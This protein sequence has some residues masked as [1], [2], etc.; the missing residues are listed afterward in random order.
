L[1]KDEAGRWVVARELAW[2]ELPARVEAVIEERIGRLEED[3]KD[4]L[5]VASVEGEDFTAQVVARVQE[6]KERRLLHELSHELEKRHRLVREQGELEVQGHLLSRFRFAHQLYQR[7]LYNNLGLGERRLLHREIAEVL[8]DIY[9]GHADDHAVQLALH[10]SQAGGREKARYYLTEAGHQARAKYAN[11]EAIR[12]YSGALAL[13]ADDDPQR[14]DLLQAR[15][16]VFRLSGRHEEQ[17]AD[18]ESMSVYAKAQGDEG[19]LCD[20]LIARADHLLDTHLTSAKEPAEEALEIARKLGDKVRQ[21]EALRR[22]GF[23]AW[24]RH[25][26]QAS[27]TALASA[28]EL[29]QEEGLVAK[30]ASCLHYLSLTLSAL[31][32]HLVALETAERSVALSREAGDPRQEA[33]GLRRMALAHMGLQ[34]HAEALPLTQQALILHRELGD[35][36]EEGNDLNALGTIRAWLQDQ[37]VSERYLRESLE[38]AITIGSSATARAAAGNLTELHYLPRGDYEFLLAFAES[39]IEELRGY[40]DPLLLAY[41]ESWKMLAWR[42]LGEYQRALECLNAIVADTEEIAS[43]WEQISLHWNL[44]YVLAESGDFAGARQK[45]GIGLEN[46]KQMGLEVLENFMQYPTALVSLLEGNRDRMQADLDQLLS[47]LA[48]IRETKNQ[49][50]IASWLDLASRLSLA[51]RQSE[52]ALV[53]SAEAVQLLG[54]APNALEPEVTFF[55]HARALFGAG[56]EEEAIEYL[57]RAFDRV[58][59]VAEKTQNETWRQ[60]WLEKRTNREIMDLYRRKVAGG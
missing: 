46:A 3:L 13:L 21:A 42:F 25:E 15:A 23:W 30:A 12:Y 28:Y 6:I 31:D 17:W 59:L 35:R 54:S 55:T 27:K 45:I 14:F 56:R 51:L 1:G 47:S 18:V 41:C 58:M 4:L 53:Y 7:Y 20:A 9:A 8:E 49:A 38:L 50:D 44:G 19:Q 29:F 34:Q 16:N 48:A 39:M 22:M 2:A 43:A 10:Y 32:E 37:E 36:G 52:R 40:E 11:A 33:T 26:Y 24:C 60:S 57:Q 5:S